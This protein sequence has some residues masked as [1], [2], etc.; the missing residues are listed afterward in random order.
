MMKNYAQSVEMNHNPNWPYI[1]DHGKTNVLLNLI[2]HQRPD[3]DKIY[4]YVKDPFELLLGRKLNISL[5]VISQPY[6]KV[7][8]TIRLNATRYFIM[9]NPN[10]K[11][12]QQIANNHSPDIDYKDFMNL[13][14]EY[15]KEPYSFLMNDKTFSSDYPLRFRRNIL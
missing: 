5:V 9:R 10:K 8:K 6:F 12:L 3:I 4:L 13:N 7:S 15:T 2:K 14:K 11:E 1:P